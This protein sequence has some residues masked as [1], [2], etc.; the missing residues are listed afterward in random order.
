MSVSL[1]SVDTAV[2][3]IGQDAARGL[4]RPMAL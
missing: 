4:L 1:A 2:F 3:P